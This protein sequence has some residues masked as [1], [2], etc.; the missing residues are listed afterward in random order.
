MLSPFLAATD[1]RPLNKKNKK[2]SPLPS[3]DCRFLR[4]SYLF[5]CSLVHWRGASQT[6]PPPLLQL[7][8]SCILLH[9]FGGSLGGSLGLAY[10][11]V[12]WFTLTWCSSKL[13]RGRYSSYSCSQPICMT[14]IL[15]CPLSS[16]AVPRNSHVSL[17]VS[18]HRAPWSPPP[19]RAIVLRATCIGGSCIVVA[20]S[21]AGHRASFP[22]SP[23]SIGSVTLIHLFP[24]G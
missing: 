3:A 1:V 6:A 10:L 17:W 14:S 19:L 20:A 11:H 12:R 8:M 4:A 2:N 22:H 9:S 21:S 24:L 16:G 5:A 23:V 15:S 7:L 18:C 13:H